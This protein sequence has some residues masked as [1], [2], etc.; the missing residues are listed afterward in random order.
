MCCPV[1]Q[2]SCSRILTWAHPLL[3]WP[4]ARRS[5]S[6]PR[7]PP[8]PLTAAKLRDLGLTYAARFA[9]TEAKLATYLRRK[10][11]E[12][13]W[14]EDAPPL[15]EA[16]AAEFAELGYVNDQL[17]AEGKAA[18]LGRKGMGKLR[19]KSTL[20]AAGIAEHIA[21][22]LCDTNAAQDFERA[23]RFAERRHIG[24][25]STEDADDKRRNRWLG[26]LLR[27]GHPPQV[28]YKIVRLK[29]VAEADLALSEFDE[30]MPV[31]S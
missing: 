13:G 11:R 25:Y 23:L 16:L 6:S 15:P 19:V 4:M 27:S 10:L 26:A 12:R 28:A 17:F 18:A 21:Q 7:P 8:L 5:S 24:P 31:N 1:E 20:R 2:V 9:T 29:S 30:S 14:A 22:P 3:C